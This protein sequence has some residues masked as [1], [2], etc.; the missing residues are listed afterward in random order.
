MQRPGELGYKGGL[1]GGLFKDNT[2]PEVA[3]F[4]G[5][6]TRSELTQ[7]PAGYR[8]PSPSHPYGL[9]PRQERAKPFNLDKRGTGE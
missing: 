4:A 7:P 8:T 3:T 2:K 5:E 6:P 9:S 1:F